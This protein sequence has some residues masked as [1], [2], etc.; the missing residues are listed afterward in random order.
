MPDLSGMDWIP[1]MIGLVIAGTG[2]V[3][4]FCW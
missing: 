4:V 2:R 3:M 1:I